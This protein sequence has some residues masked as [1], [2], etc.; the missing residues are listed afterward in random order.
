[1]RL[2]INKRIVLLNVLS[3]AV[4][5]AAVLVT[6]RYCVTS[7][8]EAGAQS[9]LGRVAANVQNM[10]DDS[11]KRLSQI[12]WQLA[13]REGFGAAI[14]EKN[15]AAVRKMCKE[16]MEITGVSLVTI[17]DKDGRV[18]ARGH[19]DEADDDV[20]NQVN[21]VRSLA[22][23]ISH[24]IEEGTVVKLSFRG[25][26]PV[27]TQKGIVGTVT[28]GYDSL[29]D[30]RFVDGVKRAYDVECTF[31]QNDVRVS[32]TLM[33]EGIRAVGTRMDNVDV[34]R[35]VLEE[36]KPFVR[37]NTILGKDYMSA[38]WPLKG[39]DGRTLGMM[40]IGKSREAINGASRAVVMGVIVATCIIAVLV[41]IGMSVVIT[42]TVTLP[43]SQ[44]AAV[45][46][47]IAEASDLTKR[48]PVQS[49]DEMG[50]MALVIN[51][52]LERLQ[53]VIRQVAAGASTLASS[54]A[55]LSG[56]ANYLTARASETTDQSYNVAASVQQLAASM[57]HVATVSRQMSGN[58]GAVAS[59]VEQLTTSISDVARNAEQAVQ[60]ADSAASLANLTNATV[61]ELGGAADEIGRVVELIEEIAEQT[62]LLAL[63]ATIEAARAGDAGKG[64]AVV[65]TEVKELA[66]QTGGATEDIRKRVKG[67][68]G[69]TGQAI[70]SIGEISQVITKV[71]GS[72]R[73]IAQAVEEQCVTTG[74]IAKRIA[75]TATDAESVSHDV[76]EVAAVG[77]AINATIATVD[78]AARQT[79]EGAA[80]TQQASQNLA[81]IAEQ[82][83]SLV[84]QFHA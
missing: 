8:F 28:V 64:F 73:T 68:Q 35:T 76:D 42:R 48:L 31:F 34:V 26:A 33:R 74:Q 56:T 14:E 84:E 1:M 13:N 58:A 81:Q 18:V 62:N 37:S 3:L 25:G 66:R 17:A 46:K 27:R 21:V 67:I 24:G 61:G 43:L 77:N 22:G 54:S 38:Y 16:L 52:F 45:L 80:N 9:D 83:H 41:A 20:R 40:F 69:S 47:G 75:E 23:E 51:A 30:H 39:A 55:E 63:N 36:G 78:L 29:L 70:R 11:L 19:S 50:E 79:R 12:A 2:S 44:G 57:G 82:L 60:V 15:A 6:A 5:A 4:L 72:F 59:A 53:I 49:R 71:N 10:I 7:H 65:A 32:T